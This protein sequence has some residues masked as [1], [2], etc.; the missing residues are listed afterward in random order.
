MFKKRYDIGST[1]NYSRC[2]FS[3]FCSTFDGCHELS[4]NPFPLIIWMNC[5]GSN[6][7]NSIVSYPTYDSDDLLKEFLYKNTRIRRQSFCW[8]SY[9]TNKYYKN[10]TLRLSLTTH[11][12]SKCFR[13][14]SFSRYLSHFLYA[15]PVFPI[16]ILKAAFINS[17]IWSQSF[18]WAFATVLGGPRGIWFSF[19][20]KAKEFFA[21]N[22][23]KDMSAAIYVIPISQSISFTNFVVYQVKVFD[24]FEWWRC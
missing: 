4:S 22:S 6:L 5:Y 7:R 14:E 3:T 13:A 23:N 8:E 9:G 24:T 15:I 17:N 2:T 19:V 12:S 16:S 11:I 10:L 20:R 1:R 18:R 21:T